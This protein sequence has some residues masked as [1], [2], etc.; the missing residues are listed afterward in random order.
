MGTARTS[1][2][3]LA[4]L[5]IRR[6]TVGPMSSSMFA[7]ALAALATLGACKGESD[8]R[9]AKGTCVNTGKIFP[10]VRCSVN[11]PKAACSMNKGSEWFP[12]ATKDGVDRC[13]SLGATYLDGS[14]R[15]DTLLRQT[16]QTKLDAG[17]T[18]DFI[19]RSPNFDL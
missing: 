10:K 16:F 18:V 11:Y 9:M 6:G 15:N 8:P 7:V 2:D 17:E 14:K 19:D 13:A 3:V 5:T 12:D 1:E 4:N